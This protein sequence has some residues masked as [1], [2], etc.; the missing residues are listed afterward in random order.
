LDE[1]YSGYYIDPE[2]KPLLITTEPSSTRVIGW[3][4]K[5]GKARVVT[6]QSGHD[7]H[8][9]GNASFRK[10]LKQA[11]FWAVKE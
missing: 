4:K 5:Y 3:T 1:T 8:T 11:I 9:F 6:L 10:L 7:A 2:A